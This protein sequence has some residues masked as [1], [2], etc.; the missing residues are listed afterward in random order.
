MK[1]F[2]L[3][4]EMYALLNDKRNCISEFSQI[5]AAIP[6]DYIQK[7]R[8]NIPNDN[9][10][11]MSS[12]WLEDLYILSRSGKRIPTNDIKCKDIQEVLNDKTKPKCEDKWE[13]DYEQEIK[14][15]KIWGN[16]F[17]LGIKNKI[18]EFH[19]KSVHNIVY[20]EFRL[21]QI[22]ISNTGGLCRLCKNHFV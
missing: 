18:S 8:G 1:D 22:G 7:L 11:Q 16:I 3:C 15:K 10:I 17:K 6:K 9:D 12:I 2:K 14:W 19:Y 21:K 4:N 20:T 13:S 5:K